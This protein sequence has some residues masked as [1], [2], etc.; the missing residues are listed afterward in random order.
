MERNIDMA[1][2]GDKNRIKDLKKNQGNF[3]KIRWGFDRKERKT[4]GNK[5]RS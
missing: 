2:K 4:R 1:E 5:K 3:T